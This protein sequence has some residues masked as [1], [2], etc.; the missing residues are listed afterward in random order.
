[1]K[2]VKQFKMQIKDCFIKCT[3][4]WRQVAAAR[5]TKIQRTRKAKGLKRTTKDNSAA[6]AE[7]WHAFPL[8]S[9]E[10]DFTRFADYVAEI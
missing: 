3:F 8:R 2:K 10:C 5:G 4:N 6:V 7:F 9:S 1:M